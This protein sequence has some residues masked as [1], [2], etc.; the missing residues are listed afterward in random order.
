[1]KYLI[2]VMLLAILAA[3]AWAGYSMLRKEPHP[4]GESSPASKK[5]ARALA[6]RV[7]LSILAFALIWLSHAL[8]WIQPTGITLKP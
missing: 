5:M 1:M 8:G 2:G 6:W 4:S 7:G 3:L